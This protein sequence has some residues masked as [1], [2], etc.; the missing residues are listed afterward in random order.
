[1]LPEQAAFVLKIAE[2][3]NEATISRAYKKL[4][5]IYHPD[6]ATGSELKFKLLN[7][8][9]KVMLDNAE[10]VENVINVDFEKMVSR[11]FGRK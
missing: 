6:V 7:K 10:P 1:M 2:D 9:R 5:K 4:A 8:A 3:A 11:G